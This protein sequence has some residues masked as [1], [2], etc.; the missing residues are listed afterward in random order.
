MSNANN[1]LV[2]KI[3]GPPAWTFL[4]SVTFG[5]PIEPT[6]EHKEKYKQFF[7]LAGDV[8]PC[9]YCRDSYKDFIQSGCT[10]LD[11][12][13]LEN[14]ES[15]TRWM[16]DIH[17]R[18]NKKL[19]VEY[20]ISYDDVVKRYESYR[21]KCSKS[22][23]QKG[24]IMPLNKKA[25]SYQIAKTKD[26]PVIPFELAEKFK[27]YARMRGLDTIDM[28]LD[29]IDNASLEIQQ[30]NSHLWAIR[31]KKC[32]SLIDKMRLKGVPSLEENGEWKGLPTKD[33]LK[34]IMMVSSNLE[35]DIL[36]DLSKKVPCQRKNRSKKIFKLVK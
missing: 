23:K 15:L 32:T 1:G 7:E 21:A 36:I 5:Y 35:K 31:N 4:H 24:C 22:I 9:K 16:Y 8:L 17:E 33:E 19:G 6:E 28:F 18:V 11:D 12:D 25:N 34:L 2:T 29:N 14:R 13:K 27:D 10:K 26:C 3:W 30:K 20:G